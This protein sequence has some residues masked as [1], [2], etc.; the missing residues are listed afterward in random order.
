LWTAYWWL[1]SYQGFLSVLRTRHELV[2]E[3]DRLLV[4]RL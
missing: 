2:L 1:E 3:N 4:F